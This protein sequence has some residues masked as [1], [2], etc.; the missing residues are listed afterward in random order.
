MLSVP[1]APLLLLFRT[2]WDFHTSTTG[3]LASI[4]LSEQSQFMD[5]ANLTRALTNE[6]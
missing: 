2:C 4:L 3:Y 1:R 5:Q 6:I